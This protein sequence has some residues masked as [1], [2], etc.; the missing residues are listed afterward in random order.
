[1]QKI[2]KKFCYLPIYFIKELY[3]EITLEF[4]KEDE[5]GIIIDNPYFYLIIEPILFKGIYIGKL[6]DNYKKYNSIY[7][8]NLDYIDKFNPWI[9]IILKMVIRN[10]KK[11]FWFIKLNSRL[12]KQLKYIEKYL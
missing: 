4:F 11:Y 8:A 2:P 1:M 3:K 6:F 9:F 5:N 10:Y 12:E 7:I